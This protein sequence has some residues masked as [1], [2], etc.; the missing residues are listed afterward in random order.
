MMVLS[1]AICSNMYIIYWDL[2]NKKSK[3]TKF[4]NY[5]HLSTQNS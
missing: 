1:I 2:C 4:Y 3:G 5:K